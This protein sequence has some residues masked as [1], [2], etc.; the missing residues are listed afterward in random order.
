[1]VHWEEEPPP[2]AAAAAAAAAA[3]DPINVS[4]FTTKKIYINT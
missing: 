1:M 3:A 2:P 4:A